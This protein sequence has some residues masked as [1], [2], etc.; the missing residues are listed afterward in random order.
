MHGITIHLGASIDTVTIKNKD[1]FS[2]IDRYSARNRIKRAQKYAPNKTRKFP[3]GMEHVP[4]PDKITEER[5]RKLLLKA[6]R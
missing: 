4:N 2:I 6:V 1:R 5:V 3:I